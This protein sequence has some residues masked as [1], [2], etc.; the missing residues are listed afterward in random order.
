MKQEHIMVVLNSL[1]RSL[2]MISF[3]FYIDGDDKEYA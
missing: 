3:D 2:K 1:N